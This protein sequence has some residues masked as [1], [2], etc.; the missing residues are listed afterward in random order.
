MIAGPAKDPAKISSAISPEDAIR[1]IDAAGAPT[2]AALAAEGGATGKPA[3]ASSEAT[4]SQDAE[5]EEDDAQSVARSAG[6]TARPSPCAMVVSIMFKWSVL[7]CPCLAM[8]SH[9][10]VSHVSSC[11]SRL[12]LHVPNLCRAKKGVIM[13]ENDLV[14]ENGSLR[15]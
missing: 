14:L 12:S 3:A 15:P 9:D 2:H 7:A 5:E 11:Q 4:V 6:G 8:S 13:M 10:R 1:R